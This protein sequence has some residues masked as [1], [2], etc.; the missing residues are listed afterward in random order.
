MNYFN[1]YRWFSKQRRRANTNL[2][3]LRRDIETDIHLQPLEDLLQR[4]ETDATHGLSMNVARARLA[5][6]GPNTLTPPKKPSSLLKFLRL[7]FG[8]FSSLIWVYNKISRGGGEGGSIFLCHSLVNID[9]GNTD[10]T[11]DITLL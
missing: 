4:L 11:V 2:E 9:N 10:T 7:C 3:S 5:E 6:T 1:I 8:G